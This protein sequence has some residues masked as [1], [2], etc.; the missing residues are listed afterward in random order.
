LRRAAIVRRS[1]SD[2]AAR[3]MATTG[4]LAALARG[5]EIGIAVDEQLDDDASPVRRWSRCHG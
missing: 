3:A 5:F 1:E 4:C 2:S